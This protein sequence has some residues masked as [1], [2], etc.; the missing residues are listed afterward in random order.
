MKRWSKVAE[1]FD[2]NR[3]KITLVAG[4]IG[5]V[6]SLLGVRLGLPFDWAWFTIFLCGL[7]IVWGAAVAMYE[8]FDVKADLLVSLALIAAVAIGE[9][10]AA[11]EIAFIMQLGA[12][13]EEFTVSKAQ[14]GI[15]RLVKLTP[16]TARIVRDGKEEV[17]PADV[18]I[19]GDV[20]RVLPGEV[21]PVDGTILTGDT[22]IDQSVMTGESMPVDKTIGDEVFSGTVNQFG[23]FDMTA[24]KEGEDSSI[25][26]MIKLVKATDPGNAKIVSLADRW[27]T[28]IVVIALLAAVG[29]YVVTGEIIR[30]VTILVVFCP[31]ALVLA[32]PAVIMAAISNASQHGFL[33][34]RG[35]IMERLAKVDTMT[36]DKTGTLTYGTP[37]VIAIETVGAMPTDQ[38]YRLVAS[39]E[40][41]SEH[42]LGKA[43][44]KGFTSRHGESLDTVDSSRMVPGKGLEATVNTKSVLAGNE[45]MMNLSSVSIADSVKAA[46]HDHLNRGASIVYVAI[47]GVLAGYVAL[48]DRVRRESRAV[49]ES[50]ND[51]HVM[52]VLLTGDHVATAKTIGQRLNVPNVIADCLPEDKMDTVAK[53]QQ[54]GNIVAMVGDGVNDAPA[55]KK[56]DVGIAMGGVG[57]YIA[58]EAA[59]IV[60]VNDNVKEIPHLVALSKRMMT[61]IKVNLSFS[62]LLNFVAI[63]LAMIGTLSPVW[64]ALVHN[65][66][67]LLVVANSALLL[68]WAYK[69]NHV[70]EDDHFVL[71]KAAR[72]RVFEG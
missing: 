59:D 71:V 11:A 5:V 27:A 21:I 34:R 62:L 65:G 3:E 72:K 51:L 14:A 2:L 18:V 52:P 68:R 10:F 53:L 54:E 70:V 43:I 16:T 63:I 38:L 25:Q 42:P 12:M 44:V 64:G 26:R 17:L 48:A 30:A 40:T 6:F 50:L 66:G 20:I 35:N 46:V 24:T 45:A 57:S 60:L 36:F 58:V 49:V 7:P 69:S 9:V 4:G 32:T 55:L 47:D 67:S 19:V 56:S 22:A 31:C 29:T 13:L 61:T 8:E 28:W 1:W 37:E 15:E 33:V 39:V 41:K 23:A